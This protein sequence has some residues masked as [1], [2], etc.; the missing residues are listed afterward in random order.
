LLLVPLELLEL[1]ALLELLGLLVLLELLVLLCRRLSF[2]PRQH[3]LVAL[4]MVCLSLACL[5]RPRI[6]ILLVPLELLELLALLELLGLLVMPVQLVWLVRL[7]LLV[8]Q[9][10]RTAPEKPSSAQLQRLCWIRL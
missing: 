5:Q 7:G 8:L 9:H 1:L 4:G 6:H 3:S 10:S 2:R